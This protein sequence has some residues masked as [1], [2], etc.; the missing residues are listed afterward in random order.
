MEHL[1]SETQNVKSVEKA[2]K[3]LLLFSESEPQ[4]SNS[5]IAHR[6]SIP[7]PTASRLIK[8]LADMGFLTKNVEN[9]KY[10][11]G[12]TLYYLGNLANGNRNLQ[13]TSKPILE[14]IANTTNETAQIFVRDGIYRICLAQSEGKQN[15]RQVSEIGER[16]PI[17]EGSTGRVLLGFQPPEVL[18]SLLAEIKE[19]HPEV[20]LD[21]VFTQIMQVRE[22]GYATK[23]GKG[24]NH[25]GCIAAPIFNEHDDIV[26]CLSIS[27]PEFRYPADDREFIRIVCDEAKEISARFK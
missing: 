15:I 19:Q 16:S 24:E 6:M 13:E 14:K 17:W 25:V 8:T 1:K 20:N 11:L 26:A 5:E 2:L 18:T 27:M 10:M 3:I 7:T 12:G 22:L 9:G 21:T 23:T 4:L